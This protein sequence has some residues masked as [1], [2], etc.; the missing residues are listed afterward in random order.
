MLVG[1]PIEVVVIH[2]LIP[3]VVVGASPRWQ[4]VAGVGSGIVGMLPFPI[5]RAGSYCVFTGV[6]L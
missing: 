4:A 6:C 5:V 3:F 2:L 1:V